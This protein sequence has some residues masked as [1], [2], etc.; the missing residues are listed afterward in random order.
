MF[1]LILEQNSESL[2]FRLISYQ[3][4]ES[5]MFHLSASFIKTQSHV[6]SVSSDGKIQRHL[7]SPFDSRFK[8]SYVKYPDILYQDP[9]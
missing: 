8:V 4:S 1:R 3:D 6:C 7:C 9:E 5:F 2:M